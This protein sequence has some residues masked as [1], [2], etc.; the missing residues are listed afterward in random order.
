M[1]RIALLLVPILFFA[2]TYVLQKDVLSSGGREMTSA[3]YILNGTI[4][5]TTIGNVS[6]TNYEGWI[7]FWHPPEPFPPEA[8]YVYATKS[9]NNVILTWNKITTDTLGNPETV[10][11]Y[12]VYR[13]TSPS[14]IPGSADSI[15]GVIQPDTTYTDAGVL[16]SS[17]S[18]YYLVKA[19][20]VATNRSAKSNMGYKLYK[21]YNENTGA[22]SDKNWVGLPWHNSYATVSNLTDDL[23]VGG[24]PLVKITNMRNDQLYESWVWDPDFFMWDGTNFSIISG[25]GYEMVTIIDTS[26]N[27]VGSNNPNGL[28]ALNENTGTISDKNWVSIPYNAV[29]ANVNAITTEYAPS[30]DPLVKLTNMR[31]DQLYESWVWDPDFFMWDGTNFSINAGRGY[32]FVTIIDTTWNPT[33]F[34]NIFDDFIIAQYQ[35]P[36][37]VYVKVGAMDYSDRVPVWVTDQQEVSVTGGEEIDY[38][39]AGI[40]R[41]KSKQ[42]EGREAGHRES[43]GSHLVRLYFECGGISDI[44]FTAYRLSEPYDVITDDIIGSIILTDGDRAALYFDAGNFRSPWSDGEE[45][46]VI[47]EGFKNGRPC[48]GIKK[49]DFI[50]GL[51]IQSLSDIELVTIPEPVSLEDAQTC[52]WS[53]LAIGG[54][55]GYSLFANGERVNNEIIVETKFNV[56]QEVDL[57]PVVL[58][59]FETIYDSR[60]VLTITKRRMMP[61]NFAFSACPNP[62]QGQSTITYALPRASRVLLRIYDVSGRLVKTLESGNKPAG[63]YTVTWQTDDK[64]DREVSNGIYF[65][66]F[67]ASDYCANQKIILLK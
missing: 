31:N 9:G 8:P 53:A 2:Q 32:E 47:A 52:V 64:Q 41:L 63:F 57:R 36:A 66:K 46:V 48:F 49:F 45:C 29:Y 18:Y 22:T 34:S 38:S 13:N 37:N 16:G 59:G 40:Y 39:D 1:N 19:V 10:H 15:G 17:N 25:R 60:E 24:D 12:V 61:V 42:D 44:S 67:N 27:L 4:S 33:E 11:Y 6:S 50:A 26:L 30:G 43:G 3:N 20:D 56:Q 7:G 14:F 28:I 35:R 51:D 55:I 23:S 54:V 58:G 21:F 65:I 62:V 5:Q